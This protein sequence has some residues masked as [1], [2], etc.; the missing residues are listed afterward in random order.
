MPIRRRRPTPI[1]L[2]WRRHPTILP[3]SSPTANFGCCSIRTRCAL[4]ERQQRRKDRGD[5]P[6]GAQLRC[7]RSRGSG[8][9]RRGDRRKNARH[10]YRQRSALRR[11]DLDGAEGHADGGHRHQRPAGTPQEKIDAY[12][13]GSALARPIRFIGTIDSRKRITRLR[14]KICR[15]R[16][17]PIPSNPD[18]VVVLRLALA[19]DKQ[20]K[21]PEALKVANRAVEMTQDNT[22]WN[23]GAPRTRP[24]A[25][26]HGGAAPAPTADSAEKLDPLH[27]RGG[28]LETRRPRLT[29]ASR[30]SLEER[31]EV[32]RN[33]GAR[34][35][36]GS[37]L[38]APEL[39]EQALT[40]SSQAREVEALGAGDGAVRS[41][42]IT[43]CS[44][45]WETPCSD[46]SPA[47]R[48]FIVSPNFRKGIV[49]AARSSGRAAASAAGGRTVA[50]RPLH[51][52]GPRRRKKRRPQQGQPAGGCAGSDSGR[53]LSRRRVGGGA[54]LYRA[55]DRGTGTGA[56]ETGDQRHSGDG[57]QVRLAGS[58]AGRGGPQPVMR[59]SKRKARNTRRPLRSR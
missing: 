11:C 48:C 6:Q 16:S 37:P 39:L 13:S 8:H 38:P 7:G 53:A 1:P 15:S 36:P 50:D 26:A 51:A 44:S 35:K 52:P 49:Q 20:Q 40:H 18:P 54:R 30:G 3:P 12:K 47:R 21:Y 23:S 9:R 32:T 24:P 28:S 59:W 22:D 46:W 43:K 56:H 2:R 58:A 14:R 31:D 19:L 42:A 10:R 4:P 55:R 25:A 57:F 33:H 27:L 45:F 34:R 29:T 5:G 41:V 17:T